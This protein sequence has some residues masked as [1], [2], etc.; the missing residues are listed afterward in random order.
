MLYPLL[1][2]ALFSLDPEDAHR[3]T[4][5]SLDAAHKLGLLKLLPRTQPASRSR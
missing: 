5:A 2:P 3:F 1:R 4:L